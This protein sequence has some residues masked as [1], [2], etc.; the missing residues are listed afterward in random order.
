MSCVTV[1][2]ITVKVTQSCDTEKDVEGSGTDDV[3]QYGNNILI[4]WKAHVL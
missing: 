4:L 2:Y 3:I 1:T